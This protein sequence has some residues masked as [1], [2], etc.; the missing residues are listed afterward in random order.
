MVTLNIISLVPVPHL[1]YLHKYSRAKGIGQQVKIL[2]NK[3]KDLIP[4]SQNLCEAE[5]SN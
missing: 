4:N 3:C 1:G 5:P 2:L